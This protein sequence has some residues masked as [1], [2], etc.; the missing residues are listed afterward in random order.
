MKIILDSIISRLRLI[1][2]IETAA[3]YC[4]FEEDGITIRQ[5]KDI[6]IIFSISTMFY[7]S[8]KDKE[9]E[10]K[11][12]KNIA[13][14]WKSAI[15]GKESNAR[16]YMVDHYINSDFGE[17]KKLNLLR[18]PDMIIKK[19]DLADRFTDIGGIKEAWIVCEAGDP[20]EYINYEYDMGIYI[21]LDNGTNSIEDEK[22]KKIYNTLLILFE[23]TKTI[24]DIV[25]LEENIQEIQYKWKE[26]KLE[27]ITTIL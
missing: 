20:E 18:E 2:N 7:I 24:H 5:D 6:L 10:I 4:E 21:K 27:E 17:F 13:D 16:V 14:E 9:E 26:F 19:E 12:Y 25:Y 3:I 1:L 11:R 15:F 8:E 23:S 22:R